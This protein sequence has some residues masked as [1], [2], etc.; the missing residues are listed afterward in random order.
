MDNVELYR[1]LV[2][3]AG[4]IGFALNT[5][6]VVALTRHRGKVPH[7][8]GTLT[9]YATLAALIAAVAVYWRVRDE[10]V[11]VPMNVGDFTALIPCL[12]SVVAG[13]VAIRQVG[14][15][16]GQKAGKP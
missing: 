1:S 13:T 6:L 16:I 9:A 8:G 14:R 4:V 5:A 3:L 10:Y 2:T 11:A 7:L 15:M 12:G